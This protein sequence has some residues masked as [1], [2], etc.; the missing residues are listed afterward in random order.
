MIMKMEICWD[1]MYYVCSCIG[2]YPYSITRIRTRTSIR[3]AK[4]RHVLHNV[5]VMVTNSNGCP[6]KVELPEKARPTRK[7]VQRCANC[8]VSPYSHVWVVCRVY[9]THPS[10]PLE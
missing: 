3:Q 9:G 2:G 8:L 1:L 6:A 4:Y 5:V 7:W 10:F